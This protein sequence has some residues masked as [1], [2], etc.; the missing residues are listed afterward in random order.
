MYHS[1]TFFCAES[2]CPCSHTGVVPKTT[3][4]IACRRFTACKSSY[5]S[6][7]WPVT[8]CT[9]NY[10]QK[11]ISKWNFGAGFCQL[12]VNE[13]PFSGGRWSIANSWHVVAEQL[14]KF[15]WCWTWMRHRWKGLH[16]WLQYFKLLRGS[17]SI[18]KNYK[19]GSF[20]S[21]PME[22]LE[23]DNDRLRVINYQFRPKCKSQRAHGSI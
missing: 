1:S 19:I 16:C 17:C 5:H 2:Y 11:Q 15:H 4:E 18:Y 6:C 9:R 14:L 7:F 23:K 8:V 21:G 22:I 3:P 12:A 10:P 20:L 13:S